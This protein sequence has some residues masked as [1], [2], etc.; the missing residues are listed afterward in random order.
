MELARSRRSIRKYLPDPVGSEKLS[1]L[2]EAGALAPS[3]NNTQPWRFIVVQDR[4]MKER[5]YKV[6]GEQSWILEAPVTIAVVGDVS[7]KVKAPSGT[8]GKI[9]VDDPKNRTALFKTI[10][11]TT[12]AADH[13]VL[14]AQ[15]EGLGTCW[16]ALFEQ[17]EIRPVLSVPES[18]YVVA[19]ITV[20]LPAESPK[21][22]PRHRLQEIVFKDKYGLRFEEGGIECPAAKGE[23]A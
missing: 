11:D 3:G 20:G 12:I 10:R 16:I 23:K 13:I 5:L 2:L 8:E 6:A 1:R 7:A 18:C 22:K 15:D 14:A 21:P 4:S 9:S 17:Q 19:L